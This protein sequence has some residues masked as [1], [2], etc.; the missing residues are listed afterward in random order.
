LRNAVLGPMPA[1]GSPAVHQF[2]EFLTLIHR[3]VRP[4]LEK[5]PVF[6]DAALRRLT[7]PVLAIVGGKD[8]LLDSADTRRRLAANLP[9][10]EVRWLDDA[11]H[12]IAGQGPAVGEFLAGGAR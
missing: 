8:A 2:G 7:M 5:L 6:G 12:F 10:A 11:G 9:R 3:T 1:D 4:R